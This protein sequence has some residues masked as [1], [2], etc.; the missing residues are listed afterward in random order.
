MVF[1]RAPYV[2]EAGP[3]EV[4]ATVDEKIVAVKYKNQ[5]GLAFHPELGEDNRIHQMFVNMCREASVKT[6]IDT[7][8]HTNYS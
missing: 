1:I 3:T 5:I 7:K 4:L 2:T 8:N 6:G